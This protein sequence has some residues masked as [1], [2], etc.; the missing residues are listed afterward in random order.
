MA[1]PHAE[2]APDIAAKIGDSSLARLQADADLVAFFAT[3][4]GIVAIEAERIALQG[5]S[6]KAPMLGVALG[7]SEERRIGNDNF[8]ELRTAV[9]VFILT[10]LEQ[11]RGTNDWLRAR[12]VNR[13]KMRMAADSGTL[14][15]EEG[16]RITEALVEFSRLDFGAFGGVLAQQKRVVVTALRAT[17]QS[18]I[19]QISREFEE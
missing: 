4:E 12:L 2:F 6:I 8:T 14:L 5:A 19:D 7:P 17:Y 11:T 13:V 1:D 16:N 15:D 3:G 10:E 9:D 18:D